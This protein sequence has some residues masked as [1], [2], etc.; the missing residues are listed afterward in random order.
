MKKI[1]VA[2]ITAQT[3]T[4][5]VYGLGNVYTDSPELVEMSMEDAAKIIEAINKYADISI[6]SRSLEEFMR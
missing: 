6:A 5:G 4:F 1:Y 3:I 2:E